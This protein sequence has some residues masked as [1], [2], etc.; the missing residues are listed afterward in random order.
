MCVLRFNFV[1]MA[2]LTL[3]GCQQA[4][5][6]VGGAIG[7]RKAI[8]ELQYAGDRP[9]APPLERGNARFPLTD[10]KRKPLPYPMQRP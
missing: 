3:A 8:A 7:P 9:D 2:L 10:S 1:V 6:V 5:N 4:A